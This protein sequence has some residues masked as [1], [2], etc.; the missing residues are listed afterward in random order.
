MTTTDV[1]VS[2]ILAALERA[3]QYRRSLVTDPRVNKRSLQT[4]ITAHRGRPVLHVDRDGS[5]EIGSVV[6]GRVGCRPLA[7]WWNPATDRVRVE[8][9]PTPDQPALPSH[10]LYRTHS[11]MGGAAH[12][13]TRPFV[14]LPGFVFTFEGRDYGPDDAERLTAALGTLD[15]WTWRPASD[16]LTMPR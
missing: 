5:A 8:R 15:G 13:P 7:V 3:A 9:P 4:E 11:P 6:D 1:P 14:A 2:T 10:A 12:S 16:A